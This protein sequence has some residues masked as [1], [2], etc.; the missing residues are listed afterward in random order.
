VLL[1]GVPLPAATA[2]DN[3]PPGPGDTYLALGDSLAVGTEAPVND[4]GQPGYPAV[5]LEVLQ[6]DTPDLL[7]ENL[8]RDGETSTSMI[9]EGQLAAAETF[10]AAE[11][12]VARCVGLVTLDIGGNNM[13]AI[14]LDDSLD[15]QTVLDTFAQNLDEILR[16]LQEALQDPTGACQTDLLMMNYYNPY[17]GLVFGERGTLADIWIPEFNTVISTTATLYE[18][19]VVEM[20]QAFVGSEFELTY[21]NEGL[22]TNPAL[23][24]NRNNFDYH[25][26]PAGHQLLAERFL[27]ASGYLEDDSG[28]DPTP[29]P[30]D[31]AT[32]D[33]P[34][35]PAEMVFL[36]LVGRAAQI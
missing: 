8:G 24:A 20:A 34:S 9:G 5:L 29:T 2:A 36:P 4:D 23:F 13:V 27:A 15:P 6:V 18:V 3:P 22:Y 32:P 21:V 19:E 25:P 12:A 14:L 16:R 31:P 7:Y 28:D 35:E 33:D 30:D 26:R 17:P 11:Q 1:V 10:I